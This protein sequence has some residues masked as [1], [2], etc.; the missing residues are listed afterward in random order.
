MFRSMDAAL[1]FA[2]TWRA[3]PGVKIGQIG[4]YTGPDAAALLLSVH[5]KKAQAQYVHD[6][7]ESHLSLDQR[8]LLDA[9]YGGERGERHAGVERLVCM[10]E[11]AHRNRTMVRMLVAR[12]FIFGCQ[13]CPSLNRIARECAIHPQ[14]VARA[15][16]KVTPAIADLRK[17]AHEKLRPAFERRRWIERE[18]ETQQ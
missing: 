12:E 8:A 4:E 7:I 16:A 18:A 15:A 5:E 13:Y 3:R 17:S 11:G 9:T 14:T 10:V 2:Y 1:S 6:V